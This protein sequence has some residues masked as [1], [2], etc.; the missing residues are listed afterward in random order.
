MASLYHTT[1]DT[2]NYKCPVRSRENITRSR[3][4][5]NDS[6]NNARYERTREFC[7][8]TGA[9]R[10][11][12]FKLC[13]NDLRERKDGGLE[14]HLKEKNGME[15]WARVVPTKEEFVKS[16]FEEAKGININNEVRLFDKKDISQNFELHSCRGD[17]AIS[18]YKLYD[19]ENYGTGDLY[20]CRKDKIGI[21][22]DKGILKKV[23]EE[24]GH[25]RCDVVVSHYLYK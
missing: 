25:H 9:R 15:R 18:M 2:F 10:G 23:S 4:A 7:R 3:N 1:K 20:Y 22:Y 6:I 24:L 11:G 13:L 8:A 12:L 21:F 16:V 19:K 14:I 5:N 17:Y